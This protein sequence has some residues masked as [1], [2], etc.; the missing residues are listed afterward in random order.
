MRNIQQQPL[1]ELFWATKYQK[2]TN[3]SRAQTYPYLPYATILISGPSDSIYRPKSAKK[4]FL[5]QTDNLWA[6]ALT[7]YKLVQTWKQIHHT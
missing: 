3:V 1:P 2:V 4:S 7:Q 6:K 5:A